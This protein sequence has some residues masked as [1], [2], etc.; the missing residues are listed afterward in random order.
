MIFEATTRDGAVVRVPK[1]VWNGIAIA[2]AHIALTVT[3]IAVAGFAWAWDNHALDAAQEQRIASS[4]AWQL[5][6]EKQPHA[7]AQDAS[8]PKH[9]QPRPAG[10]S[11]E[12]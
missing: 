10:I 12:K 9:S 7:A 6:H 8:E 2:F 3:G 4:E 1:W 11:T 5:S